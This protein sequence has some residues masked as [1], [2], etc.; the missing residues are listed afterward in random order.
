M[1][2]TMTGRRNNDIIWCSYSR[3][4]QKRAGFWESTRR[5]G[6]VKTGCRALGLCNME[7]RFQQLGL[8]L[9]SGTHM[10]LV[11]LIF[12]FFCSLWPGF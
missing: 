3:K 11:C 10:G 7:K 6:D 2:L 9:F 4:R 8:H 1:M 5:V 12:S